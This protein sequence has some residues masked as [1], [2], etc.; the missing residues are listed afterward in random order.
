MKILFYGA[1]VIGQVYAAKLFESGAD[2]TLLARGENFQNLVQNGVNIRNVLTNQRANVSLPVTHRLQEDDDYD[3][4]IVTVRLDQLE[5]VKETLQRNRSCQYILFLLNNP[6]DLQTLNEDFPGKKIILGF[7]GIGG[8]REDSRINYLQIKEQK[9]TLGDLDGPISAT[10]VQLKN[11]FEKAN[12]RV[13]LENR[14]EAWLIIHAVFITCASAAIALENG[15]SVQLGKNKTR[16]REMIRSIREGF[17]ACESLGFP[18]IPKNLKTIFI[19]MPEWFS[20]WYWSKA[21]Q[22]R[23]GTMAIAPH[24]NSARGEMQLLAEQTLKIV[25]ESGHETPTLNRLLTGYIN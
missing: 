15:D 23:T 16:I 2:V 25:G 3:L 6:K 7:P 21:M 13:A 18:V 22:G 19:T 5:S 24:A 11:V 10:T 14:M 17:R 8:T 9:T 1:G 4:I 12:F 20:V